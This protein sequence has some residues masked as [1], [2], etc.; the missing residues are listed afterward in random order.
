MHEQG[1]AQEIIKQAT[2][3]SNGRKLKGIVV[4]VGQLGHIPGNEMQDVLL[5]MLPGVNVTVTDKEATVL[6]EECRHQ[7]PPVM[8]EKGHDHN[9][10][11]CSKCG[12]MLPK[13]IDGQNIVL[14]SVDVGE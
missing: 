9:V 8:L 10:F 3:A 5:A 1:I 11:K 14:V 7:G 2:A 6:C 4:E 13:I 12:A